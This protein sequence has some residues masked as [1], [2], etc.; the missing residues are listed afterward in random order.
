MNALT[1]PFKN[2]TNVAK[3]DFSFRNLLISSTI[4][5]LV[6]L[7]LSSLWHWEEPVSVLRIRNY[8]IGKIFYLFD[9]LQLLSF[10]I[11]LIMIWQFLYIRKRTILLIILILLVFAGLELYW[12][13]SFAEKFFSHPAVKPE[14][15]EEPFLFN[16]VKSKIATLDSG[17]ANNSSPSGFA[18]RQW[19]ITLLALSLLIRN[20]KRPKKKRGWSKFLTIFFITS[21]VYVAL[22]RV[23]RQQHT[24]LD[25]AIAM[26]LG[27]A[28]F[29]LSMFIVDAIF[30][31][32]IDKELYHFHLTSVIVLLIIFMT[33]SYNPFLWIWTSLGVIAIMGVLCRLKHLEMK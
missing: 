22:A 15:F 8:P 20:N 29:F 10:I 30:R 24:P 27:S 16:F 6:L 26:C 19:F 21:F 28:V 23:L 3:R 13:N 9:I 25:V 11:L 5:S 4:I 12:G 31:I 33:I 14:F 2:L 7:V 1:K 18:F 32:K 17:V